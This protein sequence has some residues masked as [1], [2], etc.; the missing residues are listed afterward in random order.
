MAG[1][2][3]R[4]RRGRKVVRRKRKRALKGGSYKRAGMALVRSPADFIPDRL[5]CPMKWNTTF[6]LSD[7]QTGEVITD[8]VSGDYAIFRLLLWTDGKIDPTTDADMMCPNSYNAPIEGGASNTVN[9]NRYN[10]SEQ[11]LA[12]YRSRR[13][14][15]S[16]IKIDIIQDD[17]PA[18]GAQATGAAIVCCYPVMSNALEDPD[19][20]GTFVTSMEAAM[21]Q[22]FSKYLNYGVTKTGNRSLRNKMYVS[23]LF[24]VS[25]AQRKIDNSYYAE[26][27][28]TTGAEYATIK[29]QVCWQVIVGI[30]YATTSPAAFYQ[31]YKGTIQLTTM[32]EFFGKA[33]DFVPQQTPIYP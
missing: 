19:E 26:R 31:N 13:I 15:S 14:K 2:F 9:K 24:G 33:P 12:L 6:D 8:T 23:K 11:L 17:A 10:R 7:Y 32:Y 4:K 29:R 18:S 22:P 27:Q 25:E 20:G 28:T 1:K 21:Q 16:S 5:F 3:R 30:P